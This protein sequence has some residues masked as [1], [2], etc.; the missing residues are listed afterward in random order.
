MYLI[1]SQSVIL[2]L[3]SGRRII[4]IDIIHKQVVF[5]VE[6]TQFDDI[7]NLLEGVAD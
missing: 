5:Q 6:N 3:L 1:M 7:H 4:K 2:I